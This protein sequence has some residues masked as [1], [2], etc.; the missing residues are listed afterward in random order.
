M[1]T[2]RLQTKTRRFGQ[3]KRRSVG[4]CLSTSQTERVSQGQATKRSV[5]QRGP[6]TP[7]Q[8]S[9]AAVTLESSPSNNSSLL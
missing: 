7:P 5:R 1:A 6:R 3:R 2:Q 8:R 9:A 4:E